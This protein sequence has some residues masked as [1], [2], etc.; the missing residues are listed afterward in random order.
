MP[1]QG[2][3][4]R[5]GLAATG[6]VFV[7]LLLRLPGATQD[8]LPA[9]LSDREFWAL[10]EDLS[11]PD[12]AFRSNSGSPDNLLSNETSISTVAA[13]LASRVKPSGVYLGVGPEQNFT[14]IAAI[15]PRI[16]FITDIRRGNLQLHLMYKAVFEMSATRA[17]FVARLFS[18]KRPADL[19]PAA[20]AAELMSAYLRADRDDAAAVDGRVKA[21]SDHL[22]RTRQFPLGAN[23]LAGLE[24]VYRTF[25]RFGPAI[26]YTSSIGGRS[27]STRSYATLMS[28]TDRDTGR[29]HGYLAS[30]ENFALVKALQHKNLIVPVVGDFAGPK[31][32]RAVGAYL[33]RKGATVTA[34]YVSN[35]E[36]YLQRNGV[37]PAFCAN[38]AAMPLDAA[39]IF[40]RP[41]NRRSGSFASMSAG[42]AACRGK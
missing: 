5:L 7:A 8:S 32:L 12:G 23:D 27:G 21:I 6:L 4:V 1:F 42:T 33:E 36:M 24:Y 41:D 31:A 38:V 30:E 26:H 3:R 11:E 20:S 28:S 16:A 34:F 39:S 22:T 17:D 18:R 35:V 19:S 25:H 14:Y 10:T 13:A 15:R 29:E 9:S 2:A 37:W 40:I